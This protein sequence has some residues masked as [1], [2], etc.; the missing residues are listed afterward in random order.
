[1][2]RDMNDAL[3]EMLALSTSSDAETGTL[4]S[5]AAP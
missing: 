3:I 2:V 4:I 5:S 1:M